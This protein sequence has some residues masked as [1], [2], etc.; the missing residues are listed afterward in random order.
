M[1][2]SSESLKYL[3]GEQFATTHQVTFETNDADFELRT[4]IDLL[5]EHVKGKRT[6]HVG[7]VDHDIK[8]ITKKIGRDKWL[9][10][11]LCHDAERCLGIDIDEERARALLNDDNIGIYRAAEDRRADGSLVRP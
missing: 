5:R 10:K 7:C 11:L 9:H 4:R 1:H 6:V 8:T 3:T 2:L